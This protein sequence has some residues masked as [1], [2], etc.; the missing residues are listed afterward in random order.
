MKTVTPLNSASELERLLADPHPILLYFSTPQCSVCHA[1]LPKLL[2]ALEDY[3]TPVIEIDASL[4]PEIAG[5]QRIFVAPTVLVFYEG[6]EIL[7]ESRF[8][9]IDKIQRLLDLIA[10]S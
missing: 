1:M 4:Y 8:I 2:S 7:R 3:R 5:Q 6:K 9:D 10:S